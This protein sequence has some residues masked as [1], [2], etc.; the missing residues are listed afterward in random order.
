MLSKPMRPSDTKQKQSIKKI[1]EDAEQK[2]LVLPE[3]HYNPSFNRVYKHR[4]R[5]REFGLN[6]RLVI[7]SIDNNRSS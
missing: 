5:T 2:F 6:S 3:N 7:D 1:K 4:I